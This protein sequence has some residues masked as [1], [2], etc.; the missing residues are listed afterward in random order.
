MDI[1]AIKQDRPAK[2]IQEAFENEANNKPRDFERENYAI[3]RATCE[4]RA[5][6]GK[7]PVSVDEVDRCIKSA[8]GHIDF[9]M[10]MAYYCEELV[11]KE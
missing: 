9:S 7:G 1:F 8:T 5:K 3:W 11:L 10:K 6:L 2:R 4:E